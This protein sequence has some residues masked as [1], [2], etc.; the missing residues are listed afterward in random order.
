MF[1]SLDDVHRVA[2]IDMIDNFVLIAVDDRDLASVTLD[3]NEKVFPV[4]AVQRLGRVILGLDVDLVTFF[5]QRQRH[6]GWN[7][8]FH[9]DIA[10]QQVDFFI[11]ED[12]VEVIHATFGTNFDDLGKSLGTQLER[13]LGFLR[14]VGLRQQAFTCRTFS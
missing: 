3:D 10:R 2:G 11:A 12:I 7:R 9:L 13:T 6:F 5:H 14:L 1:G 8:W 4:T